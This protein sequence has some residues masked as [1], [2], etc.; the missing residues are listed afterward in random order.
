MEELLLFHGAQPEAERPGEEWSTREHNWLRISALHKAARDGD[1]KKAKQL[2]KDG[3]D[4][5]A[6]D[7]HLRSTPLAWAAKF[8]QLEMVKFLLKRGA[9][10]TLPDDPTW[11]T[12]RAWALRRGHEKIAKLL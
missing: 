6:R 5:T 3:A 1:V 8:G 11:A 12:P 7:E 10:K 9:P 4:L 2:L